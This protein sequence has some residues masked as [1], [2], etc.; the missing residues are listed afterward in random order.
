MAENYKLE[1]VALH[2]TNECEHRCPMCY[3]TCATQVKREGDL[4]TLKNIISRL[5]ASGV[6]ELNLVGGNPAEHSQI[7]EIVKY[8]HSLGLDVPI[9]SNTHDYKNS[10]IEKIAPYVSSLE[11]TV[12]G[13]TADMH[14][15]FCGKKDYEN[16]LA[17]LLTYDGIRNENQKLGIVMN[18]MAHNYNLF[19]ETICR[20]LDR[21]LNI[22][23]LLIQRIAPFYRG[24]EFQNKL[25]I[26]Q[27]IEGFRNIARINEELG[28]ES[29]VVDA[30][31]FCKVPKELHQYLGRCEWG[32]TTAACDMDGNLSRCA[33]SSKYTLGNVLE[34]EPQYIW[35]HSEILDRFRSKSYL[36]DECHECDMLS[37]CGGGCAMSC[38]HENLDL[39][40]FVKSKK[41]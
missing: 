19:Y 11:W 1:S 22:D 39:D 33:M 38:G 6:R 16:V 29:V 37:L 30:F 28:V 27:V 41:R 3:A 10:S 34:T 21:G 35:N 14:D 40:V 12:H 15:R 2:I 20:L 7:E 36:P 25:N 32:F 18:L 8:A 31:P 17:R 24:K 5:Q 23:Y 26:D 4:Q 13:P 9:L